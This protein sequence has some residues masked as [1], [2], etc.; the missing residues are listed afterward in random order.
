MSS[1]PDIYSATCCKCWNR[2]AFSRYYDGDPSTHG[3]W[4][5][6]WICPHCWEKIEKEREERKKPLPCVGTPLGNEPAGGGGPDYEKWFGEL[7][8]AIE[9][10]LDALD[11]DKIKEAI[12]ILEKA[13]SY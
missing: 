9:D 3:R 12:E 7:N 11:H 2:Y 5:D 4:G 6:N 13:I 10:A 1:K 8:S